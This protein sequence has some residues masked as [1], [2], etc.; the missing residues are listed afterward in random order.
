MDKFSVKQEEGRDVS[1]NYL[2]SIFK[3]EQKVATL[4]HDFRGDEWGLLIPSSHTE[5]GSREV[6]PS[7]ALRE[8]LVGGGSEPFKLTPTAITILEKELA[9]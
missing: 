1:G 5:T 7:E 3:N 9:S 2:Y 4:W 6:W 8:V